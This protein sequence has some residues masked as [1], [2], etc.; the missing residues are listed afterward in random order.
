[1]VRIRYNAKVIL[2]FSLI[3]LAVHAVD[4]FT[5]RGLTEN[6]FCVRRSMSPTNVIDYFRL[7]SHTLGHGSWA[8]LVQN[9]TF[10][11]LLGPILEEKYG[12]W[13]LLTMMLVTALVTG[14]LNVLL[15]NSALMGASGIV[16][17]FI[18]L[19]SITG[20]EKNTVPLTFLLVAAIFVGSE[21]LK[22]FQADN[23]S[24]AA[25][26]IGGAVGTVFGFWFGGKR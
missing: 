26:I 18:I 9:L 23:I 24:Q 22:V 8:H 21:V 17:M 19:V 13:K 3:A 1:M 16:F 10:I 11:L 6:L 12:S 14:L 25:H 5:N 4:W 7:V 15:F 2:T 20:L